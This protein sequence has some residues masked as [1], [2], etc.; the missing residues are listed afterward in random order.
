MKNV[1]NTWGNTKIHQKITK[2]GPKVAPI[3]T[4]G[5]P[6]GPPVIDLVFGDPFFMSFGD[7]G[8][9]FWLPVGTD[10]GVGF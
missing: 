6:R 9:P 3:S 2:M 10:F 4:L 7:F 5:R 8:V 1:K